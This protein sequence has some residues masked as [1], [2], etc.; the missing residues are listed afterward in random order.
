MPI[1]IHTNRDLQNALRD[2]VICYLCGKALPVLDLSGVLSRRHDDVNEDHVVPISM[3]PPQ[4]R[5]IPMKL[6]VHK[7]CHEAK[8]NGDEQIT[9]L[10][11]M[12][13]TPK[14]HIDLKVLELQW[15][16]N[17]EGRGTASYTTADLRRIVFNFIRGFHSALYRESIPKGVKGALMLPAREIRDGSVVPEGAYLG[18]S[19]A[20]IRSRMVESIDRVTIYSGKVKYECVWELLPDRA[21]CIYCLEILGWSIFSGDKAGPLRTCIGTY[22]ISRKPSMA[23]MATSLEFSHPVSLDLFPEDRQGYIG[24]TKNLKTVSFRAPKG[25][26]KETKGAHHL[27]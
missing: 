13:W 5:Q 3:I 6:K 4:F 10:M 23:T 22:E 12:L 21:R 8:T 9:E 27:S 11:K 25:N 16:T 17:A 2:S 7:K 19:S 24:E 18:F 26:S 1:H 20:I 14:D 15:E